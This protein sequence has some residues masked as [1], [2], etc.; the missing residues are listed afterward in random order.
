MALL[1]G[2]ILNKTVYA[3]PFRSNKLR[4][5]LCENVLRDTNAYSYIPR[6]DRQGGDSD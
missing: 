5:I 1:K 4:A 6:P 2:L 3:C